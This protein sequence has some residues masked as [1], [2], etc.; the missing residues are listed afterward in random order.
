M[1]GVFLEA[2]LYMGKIE[3]KLL[4]NFFKTKA[5][6]SMGVREE[7][8]AG[9]QRQRPDGALLPLLDSHLQP[10]AYNIRF[11]AR[12]RCTGSWVEVEEVSKNVGSMTMME[13]EER[14]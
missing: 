11:A 13:K 9:R 14:D 1:R 2:Q 6:Q 10:R 8:G 4:D 3:V 5:K 12:D 7:Q